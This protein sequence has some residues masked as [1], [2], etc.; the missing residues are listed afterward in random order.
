MTEP[1]RPEVLI[2]TPSFRPEMGGVET[3]LN[4]ICDYLK[5]HG[6]RAHLLTYQPII[7]PVRGPSRE[8]DGTIEIRRY[9]WPGGDLFHRLLKYPALEVLYL[10]PGLLF[11][12]FL[13]LLRRGR[14]ID[15]IHT[16]GLN[17]A[18]IARLLNP[19]FRKRWVVTT[20]AIYDFVPGSRTA[21]MARWILSGADAVLA[22][23]E[24]SRAE[25][26]AIGLD[27]AKVDV[28]VTWV[29]Q[30]RFR[31][32]DRGEA[33]KALGLADRFTVL[34]VGRLR[35]IK[36]VGVLLDIAARRPDWTFLIVGDGEME[37]EVRAAAARLPNVAYAGGKRNEDLPPLYGAAD[38]FV[39]PSQYSEGFGRVAIEALS[40]GIPIVCSSLGG[41]R[42]HVSSDV[43][44]IV[45]P[46]PQP[47]EAALAELAAS[48]GR[49]AAMRERCRAYATE[50]FGERNA[51]SLVRHY[52]R[53]R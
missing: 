31:P 13:Y 53:K 32:T 22:L 19:L 48:P 43:A 12:T 30:D 50:H 1:A 51:E 42:D 5:T 26:L 3:R 38:V 41:I 28:H 34:F 18:L 9:R 14:R 4:D 24:A 23:S 46:E 10:V 7:S 16:L 8:T 27:P 39:M 36:G 6:Y 11:W 47:L 20:H 2:L 29:N 25:L 17:C 37:D 21:R 40:C 15:S 44:V 49:L 33:R 45:R 52:E 35:R